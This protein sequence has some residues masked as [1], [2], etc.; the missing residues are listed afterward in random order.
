MALLYQFKIKTQ[1]S[2]INLI[3]S[4]LKDK[5]IE[6]Y[7]ERYSN[8]T[9]IS[10]YKVLGFSIS[11]SYSELDYLEYAIDN[12]SIQELKW[13]CSW[14]ITFQFDKFYDNLSAKLNMLDLCCYILSYT[15]EDV[16]LVFNG[17]LLILN[18]EDG[19]VNMN[20]SF[21]FWNSDELIRK[22]ESF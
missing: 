7:P 8:T 11:L 21:N 19:I 17:E 16:I 13:D 2:I 5:E 12:T 18:R 10:L 15:K 9:T 3:E 20:N 22:I 6:Y 14:N 4:Y 1:S